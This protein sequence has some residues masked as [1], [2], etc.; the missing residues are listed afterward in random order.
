L[1]VIRRWTRSKV[2]NPELAN[3]RT[4]AQVSRE[5]SLTDRVQ[6][7]L[8]QRLPL[9]NLK[10]RPRG[11]PRKTAVYVWGGI[12][13][14]GLFIL[15]LDNP[16][17]LTGYNFRAMSLYRT[18]LAALLRRP[19][20]LDIYCLSRACRETLGMLFGPEIQAR[21]RVRY[22]FVQRTVDRFPEFPAQT[23]CRFLF[24]GTQ[25]EVKGG[26][27]LLRAFRRVND[28]DPATKLT[29]ITHL[30]TEYAELANGAGIELYPAEFSRGEILSRFISNTDVLVHPTYM[31]SFGMVVLEAIAH[32]VAVISTDIYALPEMVRDGING[33]LLKPPVSAWNGF[34]PS[35]HNFDSSQLKTRVRQTDTKAFEEALADAMICLASDKPRLEKARRASWEL[36]E[37]EFAQ[38]V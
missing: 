29:L 28:F 22:P 4:G 5:R 35:E 7:P 16:Y 18:L 13:A 6:V 21:S 17:A 37:R 15:D 32:G 20:C 25:F 9:I 31:E 10:L 11:L 27:A 2:L 38:I 19:R 24:V 14:T 34:A 23:G 8:H 26:R 36:F 33:T 30:P 1:D 12:V 3:C